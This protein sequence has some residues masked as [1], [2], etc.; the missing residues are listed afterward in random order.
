[1]YRYPHCIIIKNFILNQ[2]ISMSTSNDVFLS[3]T[4][5]MLNKNIDLPFIECYKTNL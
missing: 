5:L 2:K 1:M 3:S 4:A